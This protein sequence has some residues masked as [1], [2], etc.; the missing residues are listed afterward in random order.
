MAEQKKSQTKSENKTSDPI[1]GSMTF[2]E[3]LKK[4]P[5]TFVVFLQ[6]G[7][8]CIGCAM[9]ASETIEQGASA[10]GIDSKKLVEELNKFLKENKK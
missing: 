10:H 9:G 2:A 4:Y 5:D 1:S 8:H 3:V 6:N 7:M